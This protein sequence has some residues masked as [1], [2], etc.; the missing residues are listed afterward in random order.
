MRNSPPIAGVWRLKGEVSLE[1]ITAVLCLETHSLVWPKQ[2][3]LTG[4]AAAQTE[5]PCTGSEYR[6]GKPFIQVLS[7]APTWQMPEA[8]VAQG[9]HWGQLTCSLPQT[10]WHL[11][12]Q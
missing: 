7:V 1:T 2:V 9:E 3:P 5:V 10:V 8:I 4:P 6:S 11:I 12:H